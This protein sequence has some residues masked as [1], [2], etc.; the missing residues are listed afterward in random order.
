[1]ATRSNI[2]Y[3]T[4]DGRIVSIYCHWDGYPEHNG[5]ML[6]RYYTDM[7]KIVELVSLG[8]L[9]SLRPE[10][11]E[12]HNFSRLDSPEMTDEEY[13]AKYGNMTTAYHRDRGEDLHIAVYNDIPSWIAD[14]QEY[15][16]LW[17]GKEWLVNDH[18]ER[19]ENGFPVFSLVEFAQRKDVMEQM[20]WDKQ[21]E[22][23]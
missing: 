20:G 22:V 14:M 11:G 1:M 16:Y 10:I 3:R 6:R 23:A 4:P 2:A 8:S 5:E 9:S 18:E 21:P 19:D 13:E 7:E 15:A 17:N 12:K